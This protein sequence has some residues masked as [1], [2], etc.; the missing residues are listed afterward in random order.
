MHVNLG[1]AVLSMSVC[2]RVSRMERKR[3]YSGYDDEDGESVAPNENV[4]RML[5]PEGGGE[6]VEDVHCDEQGQSPS[7]LGKHDVLR[8]RPV[9]SPSVH[10]KQGE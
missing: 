1:I 10:S 4:I 5:S 8:K 9:R 7:V 2:V 3:S 6:D